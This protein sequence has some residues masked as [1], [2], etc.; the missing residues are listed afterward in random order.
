MPNL[1]IQQ[2]PCLS[3]NYGVLIHDSDAGVT[4][5]I[6]VPEAEKVRAALAK[7]GWR[8][9]HILTTHHHR[10]HTDGNLAIKAETGAIIIGP[11]G[12][13][14]QI[15]GL[16]RPVGE[17]DTFSFGN[18]EVRVL[19]T[20]GHTLGHISYWLPQAEVA[21]VGDT[22]FAMGCG[23]VIEGDHQ[24]M[25]RSL[26]KIA[27]LPSATRLYCGH[28]YTLANARF[29]LTME[30]ENEALQRRAKHVESLR[31][32]GAATLPTRLDVELET[33]PFLRPQSTAIR[34]RLGL[35][36]SLDWQVFRE[37]RNRKDRA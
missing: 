4:A 30:P 23:R 19:E 6:D 37:I 9:T 32:N 28:E 31:A 12:E 13:A 34:K 36:S 21:F 25:W 8:L 17:G 7:A 11:R 14:A 16:D 5:A 18:F 26:E 2:F 35:E 20:P 33:N 27:A 29:A 15:P 10:D 22:L 3:D 1:E 24:M